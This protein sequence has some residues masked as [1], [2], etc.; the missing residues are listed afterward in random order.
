MKHAGPFFSIPKSAGEVF[1][2]SPLEFQI[3]LFISTSISPPCYRQRALVIAHPFGSH[4]SHLCPFPSPL[5][6]KSFAHENV[7]Q[8]RQLNP[9]FSRRS[10]RS[11]HILHLLNSPS[12]SHFPRPSLSL[13]QRISLAAHYKPQVFASFAPAASKSLYTRVFIHIPSVSFL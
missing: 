5:S 13:C 6:Q 9:R 11:S 7:W 8:E 3:V 4:P 2:T 10:A 1:P 12:K